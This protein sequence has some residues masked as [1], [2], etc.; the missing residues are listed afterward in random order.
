MDIRVD[1]L[2]VYVD[3][4][5]VDNPTQRIAI[6]IPAIVLGLL[7]TGVA[8]FILVPLLSLG[9]L[10]L[11]GVFL[12]IV[13]SVIAWVLLPVLVPLAVGVGLI[14]LFSRNRGV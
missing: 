1:G 9:L 7:L 6:A 2:N 5:R 11:A 4:K 12:M 8:V 14:R 3:G 13:F 10:A